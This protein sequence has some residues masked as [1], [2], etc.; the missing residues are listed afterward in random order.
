MALLCRELKCDGET[1]KNDYGASGG[2]WTRDHYLTKVTPHR[3]RLPR[4]ARFIVKEQ[5][6]HIK[7][8]RSTQSAFSTLK[9]R[10]VHETM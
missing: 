3:A 9:Y 10:E 6:N 8:L 4:H 7:S 1:K 2:I 5:R